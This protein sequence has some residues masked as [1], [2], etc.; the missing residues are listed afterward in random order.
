MASPAETP[1]AQNRPPSS[2]PLRILVGHADTSLIPYDTERFEVVTVRFGADGQ[3]PPKTIAEMIAQCPSGWKPDVYWHASL[4]H[5]P[6]PADI[7]SFD[8]LTA[9][10]IQDWHRGGRAVWAGAGFFDLILTERNAGALLKASGC[11]NVEFC[12][13]WGVDPHVHRT[14]PELEHNKDI[15]VL[16]IGSLNSAVWEERNRWV[17]RI[18]RLN[19]QYRVLVAIGHYGE[20]YTRLTNRAKIV[21]NRSVNGCTNQRA[22]DGSACGALVF[23]ESENHETREIFK[24]GVHCIYYTAENFDLLLETWLSPEKDDERLQI[25]ANARAL[26]LKEHTE[27]AHQNAVYEMLAQHKGTRYRRSSHKPEGERA[28]RKAFQIFSQSIVGGAYEALDLLEIY[29]QKGGDPAVLAEAR[30]A[31]YGWIAHSL[32]SGREKV[33]HFSTGIIFAKDA[34]RKNPRHS[35]A[36]LTHGFLLLHRAEAT[37]GA[38]PAGKSDLIEAAVSLSTCAEWCEGEV[39]SD[40]QRPMPAPLSLE[41][42]GYPRWSDLFDCRLE[43]AYLGRDIDPA[44]WREE[45]CRTLAWRSRSMLSD[46]AAANGQNEEAL[47]QAQAAFADLPAEAD[48]ILRLARCEALNGL[49]QE[50]ALHYFEG[51]QITPLAY[52]VWPDLVSVLMAAGLRTEAEAFVSERLK[53]ISAIPTFEAVRP[54]LL[55]AL[56][57]DRPL[58]SP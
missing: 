39:F 16:F 45:V 57:T 9:T 41:G 43:R 18:A 40:A 19:G 23:N 3:S 49:L 44:G 2:A 6:L 28:Y 12:R 50:S 54:L 1:R 14:L 52:P 48:A 51:L 22:Y 58:N 27:S 35:F 11:E 29:E 47:R 42:F 17:E 32:P 7:E 55:Q 34:T 4:V 46:L 33:R 24:D 53:V 37:Q 56:Q 8:G 21:F 38:P 10:N 26:V 15:D 36:H 31:L 30:A 5:F 25:V 13:L 20:H